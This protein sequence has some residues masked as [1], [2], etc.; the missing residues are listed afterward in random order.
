[1]S[2][3]VKRGVIRVATDLSMTVVLSNP[4]SLFRNALIDL[5]ELIAVGIISGN[6][7][8]VAAAEAAI[9][10]AMTTKL[11]LSKS[12]HL[13]S[14]WLVWD[15]PNGQAATHYVLIDHN[16]WPVARATPFPVPTATPALNW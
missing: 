13:E 6:P 14:G 2:K 3:Y 15:G 7:A 8:I 16:G 1:M 5:L 10:N 12:V 9:A 11:A 4:N